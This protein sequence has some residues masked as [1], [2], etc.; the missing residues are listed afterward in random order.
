MGAVMAEH[1]ERPL[2]AAD[3]VIVARSGASLR[4][5][6]VKRRY[7][8][9]QGRWAVPGG[10]VETGEP[11]AAAA[12]RELFEET[13]LRG[14]TLRE[15]GAF[16]DPERDPRGRVVS[17]AYLA[18]VDKNKVRPRAGDD[19]AEVRWCSLARP[20]AL[21]FDHR[22]I[23]RRARERLSELAR[24]DPKRTKKVTTVQKVKRG[25]G[26]SF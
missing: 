25:Q 20:P 3:V 8:P 11:I 19:A 26:L 5:L 9:F 12:K 17:V 15:F 10:L 7:P 24:L 18:E 2:L 1:Y 16:G 13:G 6:L 21:A 22:L 14:V 23:L 4:V